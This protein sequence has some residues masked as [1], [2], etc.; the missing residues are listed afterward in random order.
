MNFEEVLR[1]IEKIKIKY[2]IP[3]V[4]LFG[5]RARQDFQKNSDIDLCVFGDD[6][7]KE[8]FYKISNEIDDINTFYSFDILFF[9][10]IKNEKLKEDILKEGVEI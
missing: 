10:D 2:K 7:I 4:L 6:Q 5:S 3:K 1:E 8:I 9:D